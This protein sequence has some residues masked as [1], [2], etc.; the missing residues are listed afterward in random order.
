MY[1]HNAYFVV[2]LHDKD[3]FDKD[4]TNEIKNEALRIQMI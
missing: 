4:V 3:G 2:V 1:F